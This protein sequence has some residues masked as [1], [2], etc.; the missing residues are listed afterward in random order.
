MN[1][2]ILTVA[3][4][5]KG[6]YND[7]INNK[8]NNIITLG[9][10]M[11][12]TGFNMKYEL[13]YDYIKDLDDNNIIIFLDGYDSLINNNPNISI[14]IFKKNNY[15]ILFSREVKNNNFVS[16]LNK[17]VFTG[18]YFNN[19]NVINS[20]LYMGYV[21]YLKKL[22]PHLLNCNCNDDQ[23]NINNIY[24]TNKYFNSIISI[25]YNN[26][27]FHNL[28]KQKSNAIFISYPSTAPGIKL[29]A[30]YE[31]LQ[32]FFDIYIFLYFLLNLSIFLY[33][34]PK[35]IFFNVIFFILLF[36]D[37]SCVL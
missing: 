26:I 35:L 17:R 24:N 37:K 8:Y 19:L 20:G 15:K 36:V 10:G 23:V 30:I 1:Y 25:D 9:M 34:K 7:L 28:R 4:H 27:I 11:K 6:M 31:Y 14:D 3:T 29:R 12:W 32:Y 21:K 2:K 18:S 22:L 13:V 5:K 33:D 16:I